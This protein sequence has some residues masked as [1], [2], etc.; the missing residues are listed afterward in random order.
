MHSGIQY[1]DNEADR[2]LQT[3]EVRYD[4]SGE[5]K[6]IPTEEIAAIVR[7]Q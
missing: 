3:V 6:T 5:E 7:I 1:I 4:E 2:R